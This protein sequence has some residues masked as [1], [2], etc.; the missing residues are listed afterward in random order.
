M[1][2]ARRMTAGSICREA[3]ALQGL[4]VPQAVASN[5]N[6]VTCRQIWAQLRTVGRRMCKPQRTHRW[7]ALTRDWTLT[8]VKDQTQYAL[9]PDHD[10]FIDQ[11]AWNFTSMFPLLGP[12]TAAQ[13]QSLQAQSLGATINVVYRIAGDKFELANKPPS[14]QQLHIQYTSRSW[15]V[16]VSQSDPTAIVYADAPVEDGDLVM[17]DPELMVCAVQHAFMQA[18]GFDTTAISADLDRLLEQAIDIDSDAPVLSMVAHD[19]SPMVGDAGVIAMGSGT[20]I[21]VGNHPPT[22]ADGEEGDMWIDTSTNTMYGPKTGSAWPVAMS[23]KA[24]WMP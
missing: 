19:R 8:T 20:T 1:G 7:Q 2:Y 11:T 12:A 3:L 4:P 15:V 9:P 6:D 17:L 18:K 24:L 14:G 22:A 10:A 16:P 21:L 13:W 5:T 23:S